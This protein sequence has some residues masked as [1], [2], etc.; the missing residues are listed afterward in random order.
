M[1]IDAT[2]SRALV[3]GAGRGIGA[4]VAARLAAAGAQVVCADIDADAATATATAVGGTP[5]VVDVAAPD[6]WAGVPDVELAVLN[7]GV[8]L[9]KPVLEY[10]DADLERLVGVNLVSVMRATVALGASMAA[11]G[12]GSIAVTASLGGVVPHPQSP[13]Y[14]ATKWGVVG[15]VRS[16]APELARSGVRLNA[17]A[18]ALVDTPILGPGT[19]EMLLGMGMSLLSADDVAEALVQ[20]L[21]LEECGEVLAVQVGRGVTSVP[22]LRVEGYQG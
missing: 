10:D 18:P 9:R 20:A 2:G 3:T 21:T 8:G 4:A 16:A 11:R 14:A 17:V 22:A 19:K 1:S 6:A 13:L 7:A 5:W 15:W 12:G